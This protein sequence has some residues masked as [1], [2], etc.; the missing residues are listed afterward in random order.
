MRYFIITL[1]IV[2]FL[3]L[4]DTP[5]MAKQNPAGRIHR[6]EGSAVIVRNGKALDARADLKIFQSDEIK[7]GLDSLVELILLDGSSLHI[8]PDSSL[9]L[10][11]YT[12]SL[13]EENPGFIT[14]MAKGIF[15]YISGAISKLHPGAVKFET[16]DGTVAIRGTKLVVEVNLATAVQDTKG[17]S[18]I[19]LFK[20]PNGR[21]GQ[22]I[23]SNRMGESVLDNENYSISVVKGTLPSEPVF[24][25]KK[26]L[27]Q[28]IP[29]SLYPIVFE[30]YI[31]P[32]AYTE[33]FGSLTDQGIIPV[34]MK[35]VDSYSFSAP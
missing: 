15:V 35:K 2:F 22:V 25:D 3:I 13:V 7:T 30:D 19:V 14:R 10:T 1:L 21:V 29:K 18:R 24:M 32:L 16:P 23:I 33:A 9:A 17:R 5:V 6:L 12:F 34:R 20:D 26:T 31:P 4:T 8:G 11:D 27:E 28:M